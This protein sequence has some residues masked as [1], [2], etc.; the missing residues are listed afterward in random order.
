MDIELPESPGEVVGDADVVRVE[1]KVVESEVERE[2][3]GREEEPQEE[4]MRGHARRAATQ[5]S[6]D[7]PSCLFWNLDTFILP[8]MLLRALVLPFLAL[9]ALAADPVEQLS[10]LASRG[11][12]NIKLD[13]RGFDLITSPKRTWSVTIQLTALSQRH[14]CTMCK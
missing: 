14:K 6:L 5:P 7:F 9:A 12:G 10:Q 2:E 3:G 4:R 11:N 8:I 13:T 1:T